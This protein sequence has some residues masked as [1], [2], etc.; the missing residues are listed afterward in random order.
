MST[1]NATIPSPETPVDQMSLV[2]IAEQLEKVTSWIEAQRVRER[3][4]RNAYQAIATEVE[5]QVTQIRA[6]AQR[7]VDSQRRRLT[8][9]DGLLGRRIEEEPPVSSRASSNGHS[10][11]SNGTVATAVMPKNIAEAI[12][13]IWTNGHLTE[14]LTTDEIAETLPKIG[15]KSSAAR[16]SLKSSVNQA[17]AKL[18]RT[19][20]VVRFRSDGTRIPIKDNKSRARKYMAAVCLPEDEVD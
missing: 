12:L 17:L 9:F 20:H 1:L 2:E 14:A 5:E 3:E 16:A 19:G 11:R 18:C 7:L 13:A 15:Y 10:S 8:S 4:A 6:Y